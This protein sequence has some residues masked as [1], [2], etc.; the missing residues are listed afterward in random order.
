MGREEER[1]GEE[2]EGWRE[3]RKSQGVTYD[4]RAEPALKA[5]AA[6]VWSSPM[7]ETELRRFLSAAKAEDWGRSISSPY[8][9]L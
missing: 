9:H 3:D 7:A 1:S 5:D 6:G 4:D 8:R 2:N